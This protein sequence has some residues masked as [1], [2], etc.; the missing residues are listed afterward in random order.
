M[1]AA[2]ARKIGPTAP[3]VNLNTLLRHDVL[4]TTEM[5][6]YVADRIA[7]AA[8]VAR[9]RQFPYQYFAA[10]VDTDD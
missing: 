10:Y 6:N 7:V 5:V 8:E 3:R 9:S 1:W 2:I 4:A